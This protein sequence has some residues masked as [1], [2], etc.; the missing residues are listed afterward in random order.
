MMMMMMMMITEETNSKCK[1]SGVGAGKAS[2]ERKPRL[3][4]PSDAR[5][6]GRAPRAL[7]TLDFHIPHHIS[8]VFQH[9]AIIFPQ[10]IAE[11]MRFR[12][13]KKKLRELCTAV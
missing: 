7:T 5:R 1:S 4:E 11:D 13:M 3:T 12:F 9:S 8:I 2:I 10:Y 6:D